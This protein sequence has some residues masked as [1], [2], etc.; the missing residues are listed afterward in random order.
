L[1]SFT[2]KNAKVGLATGKVAD[3][4]RIEAASELEYREP[5]G[6]AIQ[7]AKDGDPNSARLAFGFASGGSGARQASIY[8]IDKLK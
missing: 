6:M 4:K 3:R 7:L 2:Q 5:E 1:R 8:Y